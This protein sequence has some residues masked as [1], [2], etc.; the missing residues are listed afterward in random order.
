[1]DKA[2]VHYLEEPHE[3]IPNELYIFRRKKD[4]KPRWQ[5]LM[6]VDGQRDVPFTTKKL[7]K[8]EAIKVALERHGNFKVDAAMGVTVRASKLRWRDVWQEYEESVMQFKRDRGDITENRFKNRKGI[9]KNWIEPWWGA[10]KVTPITEKIMQDYWS[11]RIP[12]GQAN[13]NTLLDQSKT[14]SSMIKF[15]YQRQHIA[16]VPPI[17]MPPVK[18][19]NN[20]RGH[21]TR[22]Q[23]ENTIQQKL[24]KFINET[25]D[26][27]RIKARLV[28]YNFVMFS[29]Y[30]G[31]RVGTCLNLKWKD[32]E[33]PIAWKSNDG[34]G[35][36]MA[37]E[38]DYSKET[39]FKSIEEW[40]ENSQGAKIGFVNVQRA[41]GK[42]KGSYFQVVPM[43]PC[44][45]LLQD[46][47]VDMCDFE[48]EDYVVEPQQNDYVFPNFDGTQRKINSIGRMH[49]QQVNSIGD[50]YKF[51]KFG[52]PLSSYC[53]RHSYA[54]WML[55]HTKLSNERLA[56]NMDTSVQ[57]LRDHYAHAV[58]RDFAIELAGE[59]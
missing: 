34:S 4:K 58:S 12:K 7:D 23:I 46:Y 11:W 22:E 1:M 56:L 14:L 42:N 10:K 41:T 50:A 31:I 49:R 18:K 26:P 6:I 38:G 35:K 19:E 45:T 32:L 16:G 43:A 3:I 15:A 25:N 55:I 33:L 37:R 44:I 36:M 27:D 47:F 30:T 2:Y 40:R 20:R 8:T 57:H 39:N 29:V 59:F 54:T 5:G 24:K 17:L 51:D 28:Y 21:Y 13:N 48:N 52:L 53:W 9:Y